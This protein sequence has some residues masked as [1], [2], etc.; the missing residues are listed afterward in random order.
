MKGLFLIIEMIWLCQNPSPHL[1]LTSYHDKQVFEG[2]ISNQSYL[3]KNLFIENIKIF[4]ALDDGEDKIWFIFW[5]IDVM[6]F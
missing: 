3:I 6:S 2:M 1:S 4:N 5:I